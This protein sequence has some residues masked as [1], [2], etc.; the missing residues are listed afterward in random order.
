MVDTVS[1]YGGSLSLEVESWRRRIHEEWKKRGSNSKRI[2]RAMVKDLGSVRW[3]GNS[4]GRVAG[5]RRDGA[6]EEALGCDVRYSTACTYGIQHM[7]SSK[8]VILIVGDREVEIEAIQI[9][10][11]NKRRN[12]TKQAQ[13]LHHQHNKR[14][15]EMNNNRMVMLSSQYH[16]NTRYMIV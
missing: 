14:E 10:A 2:C 11:T 16:S 12:R 3:A 6:G 7:Y 9:K 8:V 15:K 1:H 13:P 4:A 5:G